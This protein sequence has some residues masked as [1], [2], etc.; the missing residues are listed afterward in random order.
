MAIDTTEVMNV[1]SEVTMSATQNGSVATNT[2]MHYVT[3]CIASIGVE[4][5]AHTTHEFPLPLREMREK[6]GFLAHNSL[7][8]I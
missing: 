3:S 4:V 5:C 8:F 1:H 7:L 2:H 6:S